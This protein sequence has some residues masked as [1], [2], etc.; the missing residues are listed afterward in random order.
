MPL[1]PRKETIA[2]EQLRAEGYEVGAL[3]YGGSLTLLQQSPL[4][5]C[6]RT[7]VTT[8]TLC[9]LPAKWPASLP[10]TD[11]TG[12]ASPIA[13]RQIS[14]SRCSLCTLAPV[15]PHNA[16]ARPSA[17]AFKQQEFCFGSSRAKNQRQLAHKRGPL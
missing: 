8:A 6:E 13:G 16:H 4:W 2:Q 17:S 3:L 5:L 7:L 14:H 15:F 10:P 11:R 12:Q 9:A 1:G